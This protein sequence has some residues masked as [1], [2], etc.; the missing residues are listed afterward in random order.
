MTAVAALLG[1]V[2]GAALVA[3]VAAWRGV[4]LRVPARLPLAGRFD[5]FT[6]RLGLAVGAGVVMAALTRW[7]V[8]ALLT[9]A[10][11]F[12]APSF[13]GGKAARDAELERIEAIAG[14]AEMLRDTMAA[15]GGLEQSIIATANIAPP[16]IGGEVAA[17]A[18]RLERQRLSP[19]LRA[20]ADDLADPT[21]DLVVAALL[22]AADKSPRRLG[23]LLGD[24]AAAA[25]AEVTMRLRVE[26][27]RA[28]T[29]SSVRIITGFTVAFSLGLM[30]L[31]RAYLS[32]YDDAVGQ[33]VLAVVGGCYAGAYWW[34]ARASED[35]RAE[36]FLRGSS[37]AA[38][39]RS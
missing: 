12:A 28:R 31:N 23:E 4:E 3:A 6:V 8:A 22:L 30:V 32:A 35:D 7:P 24:L 13:V 33:A 10:A 1:A 15:A 2:C 19:A 11:G 18:A 38:E 27:G 37:T 21:G 5:R 39:V 36:R 16:A 29:R 14:W 34:I 20:F 9:A 26:A 25:R 17:L